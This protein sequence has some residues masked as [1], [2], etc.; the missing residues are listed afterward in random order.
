MGRVDGAK[1]LYVPVQTRVESN[2]VVCCAIALAVIHKAVRCC[3][4]VLPV[5][6]DQRARALG[7]LTARKSAQNY[8]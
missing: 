1:G 7:N 3:E 8:Y 2:L 5:I 4:H 6:P